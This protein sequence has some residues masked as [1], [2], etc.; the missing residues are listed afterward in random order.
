M[1]AALS[2]VTGPKGGSYAVTR[3]T[4]LSNQGLKDAISST[5]AGADDNDVSLLY[6][7][8]HGAT[9]FASGEKAGRLTMIGESGKEYMTIKELADCLNEIPGTFIVI[10][11][12]CGSGAAILETSNAVG[13][14]DG[15][16][17]DAFNEAAISAFEY[18]MFW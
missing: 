15:F 18:A 8:T 7:G 17:A 12:S 9:G 13:G 4:D 6:I 2:A 5:F 14:E 3:A 1:A 11:D 16:D 10:L